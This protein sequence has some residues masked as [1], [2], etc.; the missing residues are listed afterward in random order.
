MQKLF[1]QAKKFEGKFDENFVKIVESRLDVALFRICF[2]PTLFKARQWVNH[3]HILVNN[4][5][6]TLPGYQLKGGYS[7]LCTLCSLLFIWYWVLFTLYSLLFTLYLLFCTLYSVLCTFDFVLCIWYW[8][9]CT[10][11][12]YFF[13]CFDFFTQKNY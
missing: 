8:V 13:V 3:G 10:C 12:L 7:L 2:F 6:I 11:L 4:S 1:L 9:L 5:V